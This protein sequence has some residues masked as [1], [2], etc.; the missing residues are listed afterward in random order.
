MM[1]R[2]CMSIGMDMGTYYSGG[3]ALLGIGCKKAHWIFI[4]GNFFVYL[5]Y[6]NKNKITK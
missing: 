4:F 3:R 5:G 6:I 1:W 2:G